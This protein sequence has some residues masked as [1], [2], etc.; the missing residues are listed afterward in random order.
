[1]TPW[2]YLV[3]EVVD[4]YEYCD[5]EMSKA[6]AVQKTGSFYTNILSLKRCIQPPMT[7]WRETKVLSNVDKVMKVHLVLSKGGEVAMH[8]MQMG[9]G[10]HLLFL[11]PNKLD[12]GRW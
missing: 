8:S 12:F 10:Q 6:A 11:T 3:S 1:M 2:R 7:R 4:L 5:K 9:R